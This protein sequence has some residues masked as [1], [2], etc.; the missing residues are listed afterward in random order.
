MITGREAAQ[1]ICDWLKRYAKTLENEGSFSAG[2]FYGFAGI[3]QNF[4][5]DG[6]Y[7]E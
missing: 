6:V 4:I 2:E 5:D 3:L 1:A 7:G